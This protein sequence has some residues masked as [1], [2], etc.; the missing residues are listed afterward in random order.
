MNG[1]NIYSSDKCS[2]KGGKAVRTQQS[3]I[4]KDFYI[5]VTEKN[6]STTITNSSLPIARYIIQFVIKSCLDSHF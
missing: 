4:K 6:N 5:K 3:N 1:M 2:H